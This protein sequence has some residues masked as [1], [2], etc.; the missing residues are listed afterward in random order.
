M[1]IFKIVILSII[2]FLLNLKIVSADGFDYKKIYMNYIENINDKEAKVL[3]YDI[4][5]NN[6]PEMILYKYIRIKDNEFINKEVFN[7]IHEIYTINNGNIEKLF[8][9]ENETE[10]QRREPI[11]FFITKGNK[12]YYAM[13]DRNLSGNIQY[14]KLNYV[15][16]KITS[17]FVGRV[18][19]ESSVF[20]GYIFSN[21]IS[22]HNDK[23]FYDG[24]EKLVSNFNEKFY[25]KETEVSEEEFVKEIN[26]KQTI[27]FIFTNHI[28]EVEF[29]LNNIYNI[30]ANP[31][32]KFGIRS[33]Q[34]DPTTT[35]GIETITYNNG[36]YDYFELGTT[37]E[38]LMINGN[39][40]PKMNIIKED[41]KI[42]LP[43]RNICDYVNK[44]VLYDNL[45]NVIKIDNTSIDLNKKKVINTDEI[46]DIKNVDGVSYFP[47]DFF[48]K[49][50]NFNVD[51]LMFYTKNIISLENIFKD[52]ETTFVSEARA[53]IINNVKETNKKYI[54]EG[55]YKLK[56]V[57][58]KQNLGIYYVFDVNYT[59]IFK[60]DIILTEDDRILTL[61]YDKYTNK[62]YEFYNGIQEIY[63][64]EI[65]FH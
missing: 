3:F 31:T 1:K 60:D 55:N 9:I 57:V 8:N 38:I 46:I 10:I 21:V 6:I 17:D 23:L 52:I 48:N 32:M 13:Q 54:E 30:P 2:C 25:V 7:N 35:V 5:K 29:A 40:V 41:D 47:L 63:N 59:M 22:R 26:F 45:N 43:L 37:K 36:M 61:L 27:P 65:D 11:S 15:N 42:F 39:I 16:G 51:K 19:S 28:K 53:D 50:L 44:Q 58:Y 20:E 56:D 64:N 4:D 49:Y 14:Y 33:V 62:I 24:Y 12:L 18:E 34:L